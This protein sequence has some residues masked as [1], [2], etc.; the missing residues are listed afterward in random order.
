MITLT[1]HLENYL[2]LRRQLGFKLRV[3]GILLSNFVR[4]AEKRRISFISTK[5]ALEW[6]TRLPHIQP[7]QKAKRLAVVR[8]FASYLS[9]IEP[10]TEVPPKRLLGCQFRRRQP[11]L[12]RP[13]DIARLME[14]A[15]QIHGDSPLKAATLA[16]VIGLMAVTG[17][18][19]G[20]V[21]GLD[22]SDVDLSQGVITVRR[23]K[24]DRSRL[25]PLDAS[26]QLALEQ[27]ATLRDQTFPRRECSSFFL[28]ARGNRLVH[29]TVHRNFFSVARRAG[30]VK[31]GDRP[32]PRLHDLRHHFCIETMLR[33][34]RTDENVDARL[35]ELSTYLG[36]GHVEGTYW[37]LSAVP[38][39]LQLA[40][41]RW[42]SMEGRR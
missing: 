30:L 26:T 1:V 37:Y 11:F 5:L 3:Q 20:E 21:I 2:K 23:A 15:G 16:T 36:H 40:T 33:W 29:G 4:F 9:A 6:A 25:L 24:G 41:R 39:L 7:T 13:E 18:R 35:P 8:R 12:Y 31:P 19:V 32:R 28:S 38:E 14:V 34:Y 27:Y 17:M 22:R 42:Q 10:R